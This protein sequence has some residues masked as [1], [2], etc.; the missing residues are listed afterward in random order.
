[1]VVDLIL[2]HQ[3]DEDFQPMN[4]NVADQFDNYDENKF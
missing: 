1:M 2:F 4:A 3:F